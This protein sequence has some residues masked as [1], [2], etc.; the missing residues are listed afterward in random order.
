[1]SDSSIWPIDR[2]LSR[3]T[4]S[5]QSGPESDDNEGV[6][7]PPKHYWS[8]TIRLLNVLSGHSL[9]GESYLSAE[10]QSVHYT[11]PADWACM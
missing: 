4:S 7:I 11:A 9:V 5:G 3:A 6:R 2:T 8:P 10:M 1:M